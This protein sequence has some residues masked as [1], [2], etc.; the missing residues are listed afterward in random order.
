M[1][2][3]RVGIPPQKPYRE[4]VGELLAF[5]LREFFATGTPE[6]MALF[7]LRR[8]NPDTDTVIYLT[9]LTVERCRLIIRQYGPQLCS[10]P[11][12]SDVSMLAGH[13][14]ARDLLEN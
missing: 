10:A 3:Q 7:K 1:S 14:S 6:S 5:F 11:Q 8:S 4:G 9:P 12:R 13:M 2:W